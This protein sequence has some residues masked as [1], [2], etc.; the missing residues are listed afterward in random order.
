VE[1]HDITQECP[2]YWDVRIR[3]RNSA[4]WNN[5]SLLNSEPHEVLQ[6]T[7]GFAC[8]GSTLRSINFSVRSIYSKCNKLFLT[9]FFIVRV[10]YRMWYKMREQYWTTSKNF[11]LRPCERVNI[12]KFLSIEYFSQYKCHWKVSSKD[13]INAS[14]LMILNIQ[15]M[16]NSFFVI[17]TSATADISVIDRH[18]LNT[19]TRVLLYLA[20]YSFHFLAGR[21]SVL[22]S[23]M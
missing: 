22:C 20:L 3:D 10:I 13:D 6:T 19:K 21:S 23:G 4:P 7:A 2:S 18:Q 17:L 12:L 1:N 14:W 16:I 9:Y 5:V 8:V 15:N 11:L